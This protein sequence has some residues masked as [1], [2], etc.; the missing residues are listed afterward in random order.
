MY[1]VTIA[2]VDIRSF[3][4]CS[5]E[6]AK[7]RKGGAGERRVRFKVSTYIFLEPRCMTSMPRPAHFAEAVFV[8]SR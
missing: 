5:W 1:Y 4:Q 6:V 8:F 2:V 7:E 3:I